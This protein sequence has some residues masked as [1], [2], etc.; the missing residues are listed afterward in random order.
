MA[1]PFPT[2]PILFRDAHFVAVS[3][4]SGM[5]V[6]RSDDTP[7]TVVAM[8][9]VREQVGGYVYPVQRLDR[10][11]SGVLVFGLSSKDAGRL[12]K[13]L[14][15]PSAEKVYTTLTRW[16]QEDFPLDDR[17]E[18]R[19]PL[20]GHDGEP[21]PAHSEFE[22][23]ERLGRVALVR[24]RIHTG[25]F[26]Q[27]RRHLNHCARHVIGD[28][29]HGKGRI[30]EEFREQFGLRRMFL[31]ATR[32]SFTTRRAAHASTSSTRYRPT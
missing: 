31:H 1:D 6:H 19:R 2:L 3:K 16:P 8:K 28:T 9:C 14:T 32:L 17:W 25:R 4:P 29:S 23:V 30:N 22:L 27:I 21:K 26:R 24:A 10:G 20:R 15:D 11:T 7:D 18:S 5:L 13:A 12:Q